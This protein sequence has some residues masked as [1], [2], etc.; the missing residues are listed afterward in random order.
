M[1]RNIYLN[2]NGG[3]KMII[4]TTEANGHIIATA[5]TDSIV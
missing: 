1:I 5:N 4:K 2:L 3:V